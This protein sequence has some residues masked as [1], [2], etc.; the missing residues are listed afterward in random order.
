MVRVTWLRSI[1]VRD[2][3][4]NLNP[5][6][7]AALALRDAARFLLRYDGFDAHDGDDSADF[8]YVGALTIRLRNYNEPQLTVWDDTG[9]KLDFAWGHDGAIRRLIFIR[10]DWESEIFRRAW[11]CAQSAMETMEEDME[12]MSKTI[13]ALR[14]KAAT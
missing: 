4:P 7:T 2:H 14:E 10:G 8:C 11:Q 5:D 13:A 12:E 9:H 1:R 3:E 6:E